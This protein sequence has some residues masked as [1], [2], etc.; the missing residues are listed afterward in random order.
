MLKKILAM[1]L[2]VLMITSSLM[3][4]FADPGNGNANGYGNKNGN[5][6]R[7][8][9]YG[10][11]EDDSEDDYE[12]DP[13]DDLYYYGNRTDQARLDENTQG[14]L[15]VQ[16]YNVSNISWN[17]NSSRDLWTRENMFNESRVLEMPVMEN[18]ILSN[19][20]GDYYDDYIFYYNGRYTTQPIAKTAQRIWGYYKPNSTGN[21][22]FR[23]VS[24]DGHYLK[25][26]NDDIYYSPHYEHYN[27][28]SYANFWNKFYDNGQ[29]ALNNMR[30]G[31]NVIGTTT[32]RYMN[33]DEIYPIYM[34]YFNWGGEG[35][36]SYSRKDTWE[37]SVQNCTE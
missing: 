30:V 11:G 13:S 3:V 18:T 14:K 9:H 2:A 32:S 22:Q 15:M 28:G 16:Y 35:K 33:K 36:I 4:N 12:E 37:F 1:T 10:H 26:F 5:Y 8:Y 29:L 34:E 25:L 27:N 7:G 23:I 6:G 21:H 17:S 31:A 19:G 24:D 20:Y